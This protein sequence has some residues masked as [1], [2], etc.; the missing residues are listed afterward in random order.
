MLE[1]T[2]AFSGKNQ[3]PLFN[4]RNWYA[5]ASGFLGGSR[6]EECPVM[7]KIAVYAKTLVIYFLL[8]SKCGVCAA[9][10]TNLPNEM[11]NNLAAAMAGQVASQSVGAHGF[12]SSLSAPLKAGVLVTVIDALVRRVTSHLLQCPVQSIT[13]MAQTAGSSVA[14]SVVSGLLFSY[15]DCYGFKMKPIIYSGIYA[16][17][18]T[19]ITGPV[20]YPKDSLADNVQQALQRAAIAS[21]FSACGAAVASLFPN[22]SF[23]A[24]FI[25]QMTL[26]YGTFIAVATLIELIE[27]TLWYTR[28]DKIEITFYHS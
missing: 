8:L 20:K 16:A 19:L 17:A 11:D 23:S 18:D 13:D 24:N 7:Q 1:E 27:L 25:T 9:A 5:L 10:R 3:S 2:R 21:A 15:L 6:V 4:I 14:R 26:Y 22:Y 12:R 28:A